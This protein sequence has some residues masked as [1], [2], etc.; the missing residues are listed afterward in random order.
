MR[1]IT[2]VVLCL[3]AFGACNNDDDGTAASGETTTT[4]P[5]AVTTTTTTKPSGPA[6]T[7]DAAAQGLFDAW[8]DGDRQ[9]ASR[10][11]KPGPIEELFTHP[12]T[13][14]VDYMD[15]GCQPEGG[16]FICS[17]TYPGGALHMTVENWPGGGFVVD[18][19]TYT[20]D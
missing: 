5:T 15:Q 12:N 16:Q 14:D 7:P 11:A 9:E 13:G 3:L 17:W 10:Y 4:A 20:V 8:Q 6:T 19:V 1:R 18:D 2:A